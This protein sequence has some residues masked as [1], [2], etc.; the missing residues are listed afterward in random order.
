MGVYFIL[1]VKYTSK[2]F[3]FDFFMCFYI[4]QPRACSTARFQLP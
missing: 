1:C 3:F 2:A 4:A